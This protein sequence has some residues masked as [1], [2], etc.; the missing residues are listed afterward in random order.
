MSED[1]PY[2]APEASIKA[3]P[4]PTGPILFSFVV[5]AGAT[6]LMGL[7]GLII[8]LMMVGSFWIYKI[9]P[10]S[11][12]PE[13]AGVKDFLAT[14]EASPWDEPTSTDPASPREDEPPPNVHGQIHL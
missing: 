13:Q 5:I 6:V 12:A 1:N 14:L 4:K 10:R 9:I 11:P 3:E 7:V 2:R 8:A